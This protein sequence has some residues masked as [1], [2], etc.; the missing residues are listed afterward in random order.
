MKLNVQ[1]LQNGN[2]FQVEIS[3]DGTVDDI[4]LIISCESG[5]DSEFQVLIFNQRPLMD[6]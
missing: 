2:V 5:I 3:D 1:D 4:K 6:D